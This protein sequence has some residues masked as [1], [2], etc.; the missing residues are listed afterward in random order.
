M[1]ACHHLANE[2]FLDYI[3]FEK[4]HGDPRPIAPC[5]ERKSVKMDGL[6]QYG[7]AKLFSKFLLSGEDCRTWVSELCGKRILSQNL[8]MVAI[9]SLFYPSCKIFQD[10]KNKLKN[11]SGFP[12]KILLPF[13]REI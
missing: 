2:T 12:N 10:Q 1:T 4:K 7:L 6:R 3:G 11:S 5:R 9:L 8:Q 13:R